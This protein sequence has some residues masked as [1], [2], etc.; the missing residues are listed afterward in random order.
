MQNYSLFFF[1]K[2]DNKNKLAEKRWKL[3]VETFEYGSSFGCYGVFN[4]K[5]LVSVS[6]NFL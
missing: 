1:V 6:I 3:G 5:G 4:L 2:Q